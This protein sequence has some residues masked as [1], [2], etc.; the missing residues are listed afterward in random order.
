MAERANIPASPACGRWETLLV[1]AL[2]GQLKPEDEGKFAAHKASCPACAAL[3][4]EAC[5]GRK[6]LEFLSPVP[7]VPPGLVDRILAQTAPGMVSGHGMASGDGLVAP[8]TPVWQL[9]GFAAR[10]RRFAEPRLM[11]TAAMAFFSI[12]MTLS[13]AGVRLNNLRISDL[14]P[15]AVRSLP[16]M[17]RSYLERQL[18]MASTPIIRYYDH[19]RLVYEMQTTMRDLRRGAE[20]RNRDGENRRNSSTPASH[21]SG[22]GPKH[23]VGGSRVHSR[24]PAILPANS[25]APGP[26]DFFE[27]LLKFGNR[28]STSAAEVCPRGPESAHSGGSQKELQE[29]STAWTA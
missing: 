15:G 11:M 20:S 7:E 22:R 29:R 27:A 19:L 23:K 14:N 5:K 12:A 6:W 10:F 3:Y 17:A 2:D 24:Q 26:S 1:D 4:E 13:L 18:S 16:G 8:M 21:E 9:S 25:P 28:S